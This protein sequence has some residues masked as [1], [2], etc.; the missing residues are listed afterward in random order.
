MA[1][2]WGFQMA[3][4]RVTSKVDP[5]FFELVQCATAEAAKRRA[6]ER[7]G[8]HPEEIESLQ[9]VT[10][11]RGLGQGTRK[12]SQSERESRKYIHRSH[13]AG[14]ADLRKRGRNDP[15]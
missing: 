6:A 14:N 12:L 15:V 2:G 8:Y 11:K 9:L 5:D 10:S 7:R 1:F 4:Y 3:I 13:L